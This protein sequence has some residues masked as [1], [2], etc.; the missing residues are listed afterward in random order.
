MFNLSRATRFGFP[1][2]RI[3]PLSITWFSRFKF[4]LHRPRAV[5]TKRGLCDLTAVNIGRFMILFEVPARTQ[6][7]PVFKT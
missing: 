5:E 1:S 3:G 2:V 7:E 6:T 4:G